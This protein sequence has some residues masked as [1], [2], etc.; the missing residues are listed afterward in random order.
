M[1]I[2][3]KYLKTNDRDCSKFYEI[4]ARTSFSLPYP[5]TQGLQ[6]T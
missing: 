2:L 4:Y 5:I 1:K 6:P 3:G